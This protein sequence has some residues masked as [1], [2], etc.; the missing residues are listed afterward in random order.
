MLGGAG[1]AGTGPRLAVVLVDR[2]RPLLGRGLV[3][4][5]LDASA[6]GLVSAETVLH[7]A[8]ASFEI[9]ELLGVLADI[10][11]P[12]CELSAGRGFIQKE[13][14]EERSAMQTNTNLASTC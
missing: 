2:L 8:N 10:L 14:I 7:F 11:P 1:R 9:G 6:A 4:V 3:G 5:D 13:E 12:A